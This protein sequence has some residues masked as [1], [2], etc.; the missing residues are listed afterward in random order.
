M[1]KGEIYFIFETPILSIYKER[2]CINY[3]RENGWETHM[4]D[5]S[6]IL[7]P[8]AFKQIVTGLIPEK[9]RELF[10][11]KKDY[12]KYIH[13][14]DDRA[15]FIIRNDFTYD[16]YFYHKVIRAS[17][18]YGYVGRANTNVEVK[19]ETISNRLC[20][21]FKEL[22]I[23]RVLCSVFVRI[24]KWLFPV[25][26]AKFIVLGGLENEDLYLKLACIDKNSIV[27]YIH[28]NDYEEYLKIKDNKRIIE[29][30]YCVFLDQYVPYHPDSLAAG[31]YFDAEEYY[32][33]MT[34]LFH[35]L[36]EKYEI[37]I[38]IAAHPRANYGK[39]DSFFSEFEI[40]RYRTA[41]LVNNAEFV[42]AHYSTSIAY[43][44]L[45]YKPL[46]F[47]ITKDLQ[48]I[49]EYRMRIEKTAKLLGSLIRNASDE[50]YQNRDLIISPDRMKYKKYIQQYIKAD[51]GEKVEKEKSFAIQLEELIM[52]SIK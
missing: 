22:S 47:V 12:K 3:F 46:L 10:Y 35:Y 43:A 19:K 29:D 28:S 26:P 21:F 31:Y 8:I 50:D 40:I 15:V 41:E 2:C 23:K 13:K 9:E 5:L 42:I 33:S 52:E 34:K 14:S 4:I 17:Q 48:N 25:K 44:V 37:K 11:S 6:P 51:Y 49:E 32:E 18:I 7:N 36:E 39:D 1:N 38:V 20:S 27:K 45:G 16:N 30:K 24:P